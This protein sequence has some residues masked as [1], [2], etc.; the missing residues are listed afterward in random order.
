M[1]LLFLPVVV[2]LGL[3]VLLVEFVIAHPMISMMIATAVLMLM[4][5]PAPK[6]PPTP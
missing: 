4:F 2:F 3:I 1:P 6:Q 5:Y